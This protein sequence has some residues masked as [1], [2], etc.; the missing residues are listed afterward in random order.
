MLLLPNRFLFKTTCIK[1]CATRDDKAKKRRWVAGKSVH[2]ISKAMG[3]V[4]EHGDED[5]G[6]RTRRAPGVDVTPD[7]RVLVVSCE[8]ISV[9]NVL[10]YEYVA[11]PEELYILLCFRC[12]NAATGDSAGYGCR[13]LGLFVVQRPSFVCSIAIL[14]SSHFIIYTRVSHRRLQW[15]VHDWCA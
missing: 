13:D 10:Y 3:G 6:A 12:A 14:R 15:F 11:F 8:T 5:D 9:T 1:R 2:S 7:L 4:E